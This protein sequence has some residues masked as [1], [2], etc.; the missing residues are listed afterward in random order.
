MCRRAVNE[1]TFVIRLF[2]YL[3]LLGLCLIAV[4]AYLLSGSG[5][6]ARAVNDILGVAVC[7]G[8]GLLLISP[9]P[10]VKAI[11][12]MKNNTR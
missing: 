10:V 6:S 4:G 9:Y 3:H 1:K 11:S 7:T 8:L 5:D 2:L 12:W